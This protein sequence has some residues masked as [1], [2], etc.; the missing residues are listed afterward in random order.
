MDWSGVD[1]LWIIVMFLSAVW[2]LILMAPIHCRGSIDEKMMECYISPNRRRNKETNSST[3]RI[4]WGWGHFQQILIFGWTIPFNIIAQFSFKKKSKYCKVTKWIIQT[5][6]ECNNTSSWGSN[7]SISASLDREYI[8]FSLASPDELHH[9]P[10]VHAVT[11][12]IVSH[13]CVVSGHLNR[14]PGKHNSVCAGCSVQ[15]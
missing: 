11:L 3:S 1:Y 6:F 12:L 13:A 8:S 4:A 14:L 10:A 2:T 7:A 9:P 5:P 15:R